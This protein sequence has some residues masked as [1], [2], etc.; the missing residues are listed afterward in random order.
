MILWAPTPGAA[1]SGPWKV[2]L[3]GEGVQ[4]GS[5]DA[6][7]PTD[8]RDRLAG[9]THRPSCL[10]P[11]AAVDDQLPTSRA[12]LVTNVMRKQQLALTDGIAVRVPV[13]P[14]EST[15]VETVPRSGDGDISETCF[16]LV[17]PVGKSSPATLMFWGSSGSVKSSAIR[18]VDHS[19]PWLCAWWTR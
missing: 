19:R 8:R 5:V 14:G 17:D 9:N 6:Q 13:D 11:H 10:L 18:T 1:A 3:E 2:G 7:S 15:K 16:G 12:H 4:G